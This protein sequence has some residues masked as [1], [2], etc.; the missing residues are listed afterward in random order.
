MSREA[1]VEVDA[2]LEIL[3]P[4]T[5]CILDEHEAKKLKNLNRDSFRLLRNYRGV[6][7]LFLRICI[8]NLVQTKNLI[9]PLNI[10]PLILILK[11]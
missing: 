9:L 4:G 8:R 1:I 10:L 2:Y 6:R 5:W 7:N 11:L 3:T